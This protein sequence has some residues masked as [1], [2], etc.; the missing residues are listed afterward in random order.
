MVR[1]KEVDLL[2]RWCSRA[3]IDHFLKFCQDRTRHCVKILIESDYS[4]Y[5]ERFLMAV[6]LRENIAIVKISQFAQ[7]RAKLETLNRFLVVN[8]LVEEI[9]AFL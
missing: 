7:Y 8:E 5:F 9:L 1:I 4:G 2:T 3:K 6:G